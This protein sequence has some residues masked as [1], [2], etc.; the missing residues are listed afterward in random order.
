MSSPKPKYD[1]D[2][3]APHISD[4]DPPL[5]KMTPEEIQAAAKKAKRAMDERRGKK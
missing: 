2:F 3:Y 1:E 4:P 5:P